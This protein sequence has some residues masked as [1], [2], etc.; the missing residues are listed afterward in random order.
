MF[1]KALSLLNFSAGE[2]LHVGDSLRA[3]VR[4]AKAMGMPVLWINRKGRI[5]PAGNE[6]PDYVSAD[7]IGIIELLNRTV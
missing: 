7:L 1:E 5:I 4:G 3:D 6:R 2:V